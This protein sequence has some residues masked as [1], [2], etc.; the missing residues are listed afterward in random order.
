MTH[1]SMAKWLEVNTVS[2]L[3]CPILNHT[4]VVLDQKDTPT[5]FTRNHLFQGA[6]LDIVNILLR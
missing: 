4:V 3:C 6:Y 2:I 5:N 1:L